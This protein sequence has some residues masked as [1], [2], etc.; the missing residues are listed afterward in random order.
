MS[1]ANESVEVSIDRIILETDKSFLVDKEGDEKFIAKSQIENLD[2][3]EEAWEGRSKKGP[4]DD[5]PAIFVPRWL[6]RENEW[7]E[8]D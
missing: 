5:P 7:P 2:E 3:I 8:G 6:A 1:D 4:L